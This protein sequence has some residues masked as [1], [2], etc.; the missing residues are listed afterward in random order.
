MQLRGGKGQVRKKKKVCFVLDL[1]VDLLLKL[2]RLSDVGIAREQS[3]WNFENGDSLTFIN[4]VY[5]LQQRARESLE[6]DSVFK[7]CNLSIP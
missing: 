3:G 4:D 6:W 5:H 1:L 7:I 2:L